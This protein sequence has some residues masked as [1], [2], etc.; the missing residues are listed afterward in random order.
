MKFEEFFEQMEEVKQAFIEGGKQYDCDE[1][2]IVFKT[3]DGKMIQIGCIEGGYA[4]DLHTNVLVFSSGKNEVK[5]ILEKMFGTP[6][7]NAE[8]IDVGAKIEEMFEDGDH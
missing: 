4:P 8:D 6:T 5:K 1:V 3:D 2:E 7:V